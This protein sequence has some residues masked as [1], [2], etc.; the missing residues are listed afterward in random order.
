[1]LAVKAELASKLACTNHI[2]F[3]Y[4]YHGHREVQP[5]GTILLQTVVS[6]WNAK[7]VLPSVAC[8]LFLTKINTQSQY[9]ANKGKA[10]TYVL[11][12]WNIITPDNKEASAEES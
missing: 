9:R 11:G 10:L 1:M 6:T 8:S 7:S 2:S 5:V 12:H 3:T 4:Y